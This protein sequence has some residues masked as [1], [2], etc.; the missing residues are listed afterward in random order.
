MSKDGIGELAKFNSFNRYAG[1]SFYTAGILWVIVVLLAKRQ[2]RCKEAQLAIGGPPIA[3][4][5]G[6]LFGWCN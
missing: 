5:F 4:M 1:I 3:M 6:I 2:F